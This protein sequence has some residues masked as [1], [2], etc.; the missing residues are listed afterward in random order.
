MRSR[1]LVI[2]SAVAVTAVGCS[3]SSVPAPGP[4]GSAALP[5]S[6]SSKAELLLSSP[7]ATS[8]V[9]WEIASVADGF[10]RSILMGDSAAAAELLTDKAAQR[11]AAD[12]SVLSTIGMPAD[13]VEIGEIR[14][15]STT[16][17][18]AQCLVKPT[19][20]GTPVELCCLLKQSQTGWRVCGI[21]SD[22]KGAAPTVISFEGTPLVAPE[23]LAD[24]SEVSPETPRTAA[25]P[26]AADRR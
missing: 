3:D 15:L 7:G 13:N 17:A 2:L 24:E 20:S 18:A 14:L 16:E 22:V 11:Y 5:S 26:G 8:D 23:Q 21:A 4:A 9:Q 1:S 25:Q 19:G 10:M 6:A 12:P